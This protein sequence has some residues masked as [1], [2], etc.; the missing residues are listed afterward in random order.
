VITIKA[1]GN[2]MSGKTTLI[3]AALKP[4]ELA[5]LIN[6]RKLNGGHMDGSESFEVVI[7]DMD[8]LR[9]VFLP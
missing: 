2:A 9:A 3:R 5:G 4:L 7:K 1:T 8:G 6:I